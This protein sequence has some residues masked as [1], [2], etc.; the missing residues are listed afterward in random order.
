MF[1]RFRLWEINSILPWLGASRACYRHTPFGQQLKSGRDM[2]G[3][4]PLEELDVTPETKN[5]GYLVVTVLGNDEYG[6]WGENE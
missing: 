1:V 2:H 6:R 4:T 5:K 3:T